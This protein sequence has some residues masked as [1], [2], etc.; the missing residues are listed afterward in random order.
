MELLDILSKIALE[1]LLDIQD[2]WHDL[3]IITEYREF[4]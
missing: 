2:H 1:I 3:I 4:V